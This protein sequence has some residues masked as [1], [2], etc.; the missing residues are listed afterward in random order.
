MLTVRI[1]FFRFAVMKYPQFHSELLAGN[2][3]SHAAV[4]LL[5][6]AGVNCLAFAAN[7]SVQS[8]AL[9]FSEAE[10]DT[11]IREGIRATIL[12]KFDRADSLFRML[13]RRN[14]D[15]PRAFFYQAAAL[16]SRMMDAEDYS[17]EKEFLQLIEETVQRADRILKRS[18]GNAAAMF[19]KGA[20]LGYRGFYHAQ[21]KRYLKGIRDALRGIGFL[22]RAVQLDSA[23]YDAYLGIG[24]YKYWRSRLTEFLHWLPFFPDKKEEGIRLIELAARKGRYGRDVA[25]NELMWVELDRKN[26]WRALAI[27]QEMLEKYP[28][29]RFFMWPM[30]EAYFRSG[31]FSRAIELF[32]R[33]M[34]SYR[35]EPENNHY[36]EI[37]CGLR[38][39]QAY[40]KLGLERRACQQAREMLALPLAAEVKKRLGKRLKELQRISSRCER[41]PIPEKK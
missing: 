23:F 18:P 31:Q 34:E 2:F 32:R 1:G 3:K 26:Y 28:G 39:A 33:L 4:I 38:I 6:L 9:P 8:I 10:V 21:R 29:S 13:Q 30:A 5:L 35:K 40:L 17:R 14:P 16:Q 37:I 27:G 22:N 19:F 41:P 36:N 11:L 12:Q 25:A 15:D 20:A 7:G 24:T